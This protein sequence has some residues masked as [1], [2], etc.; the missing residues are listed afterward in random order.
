[1]RV[2]YRIGMAVFAVGL[3]A[4]ACGDD[5][6]GSASET[7]AAATAATTLA[8]G[9][10]AGATTTVAADVC[11]ADKKGGTLTFGTLIA[12]S[13]LDPITALGSGSAGGIELAALY[14]QLLRYNPASGEYEPH[15]AQSF[16]SNTDRSEWTIKLRP[17][18][19]FGNGDPLTADAV[20]F[21]FERMAKAAVSSAGLAAEVATI[22]TPDPLT[23]VFK[24]KGPFGEFPYVL[25]EDT[26][27]IVNPKV[28]GSMTPAEFAKNP[29]GAGV[30]AFEFERFAPGEEVVLKAKADYWGG[31]VCIDTL[32]FINVAGGRGTYDAFKKGEMNVAFINDAQIV[33][34]AKAA[35]VKGFENI[36][37]G[38]TYIVMNQGVK[39]TK[40]PFTDVRLRKAV[41]AAIDP[42]IINQ[43]VFG[44]KAL[45]GSAIIAKDSPLNPGIDGPKYDPEAAKKLVA[46][47]KAAGFDGKIRLTGQ[48]TATA[49][50]QSITI[51]AMLKA[52]GFEVTVESLPAAEANAKVLT[53]PNFDLGFSGLS[54]FEELPWA[55][56]N[57]FETGSVRSRTG[58]G[59]PQMD[60]A[61]TQLKKAS[62]RAEKKAA[63]AEIQ[64][65]W[66]DT[67]PST[68]VMSTTELIA[69]SPNVKGLILTRD[70]VPLF[71]KAYIAK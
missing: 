39:G 20:K 9:A 63:M 67:I 60:A 30:G 2:S 69:T 1:M 54:I 56:L 4:A 26:G 41:A 5:S 36:A 71:H 28:V 45:P 31:P 29:K 10:T 3:V 35:G 25:A 22:E 47:A 21:S 48:N 42:N 58:Y 23:V 38:S 49:V 24:L 12:T 57:Q 14:D 7:T 32:R 6:D 66:N 18:V 46:E 44:G 52:V 62:T 15:V 43:R 8:P 70:T 27:A 33:A 51:E 65:I 55:R 68:A 37:S 34:E 19:K 59:N 11:T 13:S 53:S 64:K 61:L 40:S 16:S 17:N 50:E